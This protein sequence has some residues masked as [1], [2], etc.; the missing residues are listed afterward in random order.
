MIIKDRHATIKQCLQILGEEE[1][2]DNLHEIAY[3]AL[4]ICLAGAEREQ[5][6]QLLFRGPVWD[7]CV[8]SKVAR[9]YLITL[10]LATRVC[11][12]G[13]QGYTAATYRAFTL[14]KSFEHEEDAL[15]PKPGT[16]G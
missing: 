3:I 15:D 16:P 5:L 4:W 12:M 10:G 1:D 8:V 6:R 7:G 11:F 9:D 14:W 2:T 13:H